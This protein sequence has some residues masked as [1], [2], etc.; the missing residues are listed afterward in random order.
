MFDPRTS[1]GPVFPPRPESELTPVADPLADLLLSAVAIIVLA[2]IAILP[3]L[4]RHFTPQDKDNPK[5]NPTSSVPGFPANSSFRLEGREVEPL[6][7]SERGLVIGG[8]PPRVIPV[9]RV[10]FDESLIETLERMRRMD[11]TIVL[12]IEPN[13][14]ETAFQFEGIANL[15]GPRRMRQIRLES[16]CSHPKSEQFVLDCGDSDHQAPEQHR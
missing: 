11:E 4:P 1:A 7:A 8:R 5:D 12:L 13:G 10:F 6:V 14:F 15:H 2:M 9:G 16:N 3:T